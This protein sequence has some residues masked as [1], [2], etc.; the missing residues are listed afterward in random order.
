MSFIYPAEVCVDTSMGVVLGGL[1]GTMIL[2]GLTVSYLIA[3]PLSIEGT[4]WL[5]AAINICCAIYIAVF[6]KE[7]RGL[8]PAELRELYWPKSRKLSKVEAQAP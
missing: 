4:F 6:V 8:T 2:M 1:F 5:Y 7:T 3:S